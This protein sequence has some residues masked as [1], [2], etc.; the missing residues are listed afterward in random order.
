MFTHKTP[1]LIQQFF[2]KLLWKK[3]H[4]PRKLF[5][6]FDDGPVPE[7]TPQVLEHLKNYGAKATFFCVGDN[8]RK[9]PKVLEELLEEGHSL[10]NHT[11]HHIDGWTCSTEQY[12]ENI[13][14]CQ[15]QILRFCPP[16]S[17]GKPLFRPPYGRLNLRQI[18]AVLPRYEIVMW[19][20]LSGD[21]ST[22]TDAHKCLRKSI[23]HTQDGSIIVFHDSLKALD[24]LQK[25]LPH[26]LKY[27]SEQGYTFDRL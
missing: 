19:D 8:I 5:L 6:T 7:A 25:V 14:L 20:V 21:F 18:R 9:H 22:T 15:Q 17:T 27:F 4:S 24:K 13:E 3:P 12:L 10:G 16:R 1:F 26:F 11:F 2:P 23:R